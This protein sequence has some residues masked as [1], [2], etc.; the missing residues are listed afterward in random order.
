M[1]EWMIAWMIDCMDERLY[2]LHRLNK[3][4]KYEKQVVLI[5]S[6]QL[7]DMTQIIN[8]FYYVRRYNVISFLCVHICWF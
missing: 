1:F 7:V 3:T 6:T 4:K 5:S 2:T 8:F